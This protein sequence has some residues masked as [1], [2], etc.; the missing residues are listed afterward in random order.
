MKKIILFIITFI[1][2][3]NVNALYE[4][5]K[6]EGPFWLN[7]NYAYVYNIKEDRV[8][9]E[10]ESR[11]QIPIASLTKI[12]TAIIAIENSDL[13]TEVT[14]I[15]EDFK[16]MYEYAVAGFDIGDKVTIKDLLYGTLLPSGSD[17]VNALVRSVSGSEE[18]FVK[19]MNEKVNELGLNNTHFSNAIGKDDGN[20]SS[21]YD[22]YKILEYSLANETFKEIFKTSEY[23]IN[24]LKLKGPL[25]RVNSDL[26]A[27]AKTGFTYDA[28]YCFASFSE[29]DNLNYIVVT[30][31]ADSYKNVIEDHI[32]IY[33]YYLNNYDYYNYNVNFDIKIENGKKE[34]YNVNIDKTLYLEN[35]YKEVFITPKYNGIE[36]ITKELKK[37]DKLGVVD[38]YYYN[39]VIY[40]VDVYLDEEIE[41]KNYYWVIIPA[42]IILGLLIIF[43]RK[44]KKR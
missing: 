37:G 26:I 41:Y 28:M 29:E 17:A 20:Y 4:D 31:N 7:S 40:Q 10:L 9:Y 38:L 6:M 30:A 23:N 14:M 42:L 11:K 43:I 32:N 44:I 25:T 16:D 13:D 34:N 27:G 19:L 12:M 18:E 21:M 15:K 5:K 2:I 8:M 35:T 39:D 22:M 36:T 33:N 1:F 24:D 3:T